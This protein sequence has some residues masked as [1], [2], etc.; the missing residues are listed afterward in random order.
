[1]SMAAKVSENSEASDFITVD[2]GAFSDQHILFQSYHPVVHADPLLF[3]VLRADGRD[4]SAFLKKAS[5]VLNSRSFR[6]A[7]D[8]TPYAE[9]L[10]FLRKTL[11][12]VNSGSLG[13]A[14]TQTEKPTTL[15]KK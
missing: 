7:T 15:C 9:D 11:A 1:M 12:N 5:A 13:N 4:D 14:S 10:E 6:G 3:P 8:K 2:E